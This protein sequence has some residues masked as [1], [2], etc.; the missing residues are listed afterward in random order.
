MVK[1]QSIGG[2]CVIVSHLVVVSALGYWL[3]QT[4]SDLLRVVL[5]LVSGTSL[6]VLTSL[7]HEATHHQLARW[8]WLN[9]LL[10]N[11]AGSLLATP[12]SAY[13]A[14]HMKHHQATN[15][16]DD[17]FSAFNT[18]W[19]ILV[20]APMAVA[21][22]HGYAWRHLRGRALGRYLLEMVGM[23]IVMAAIMVLPRPVREWSLFGPLIVV[24]VLQ[25]IHIVTGHLDLPA[26]KY[27]DTWQLVLPRWL[28][29][30]LIH[31]DHHLEHHICPRLGWHELPA[32]RARLALLPGLDLPRV[33]VPQFFLGVF[34]A[35]RR[36]VPARV[37][38]GDESEAAVI[39]PR[40]KAG[41]IAHEVA[42]GG[43]RTTHLASLGRSHRPVELRLDRPESALAG[44][45]RRHLASSNGADAAAA[46]AGRQ[47]HCPR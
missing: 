30:W 1:R 42:D 10:G 43:R 6:F 22:A 38:L 9:E 37:I 15:R 29:V 33:T 24:V 11:L 4:R 25:N 36:V 3:A 47:R 20:G 2:P 13:R 46:P 18:R 39:A 23:F 40:E 5:S 35:R 32:V 31:H 12:L 27:R 16:H 45:H 14:V 21:V 44:L 17:P 7:V 41:F 19:M 26:G 28:S 8:T 34:L